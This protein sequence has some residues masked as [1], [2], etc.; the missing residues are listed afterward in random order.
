[1]GPRMRAMFTLY[2]VLIVAG[3]VFYA[4]VGATHN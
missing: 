3:I 4:A 2:F 1:L